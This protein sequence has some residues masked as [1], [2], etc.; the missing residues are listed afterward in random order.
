MPIF[1][2]HLISHIKQ[3]EKKKKKRES[4]WG[5][6]DMDLISLNSY[7]I[8]VVADIAYSLESTG[9]GRV[10]C[11][12]RAKFSVSVNGAYHHHGLLLV[13]TGKLVCCKTI[14]MSLYA[15]HA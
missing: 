7:V 11:S 8:D 2:R 15:F 12:P 14:Y 1:F 5:I 9:S 4:R 13:F 3:G 6:E 10:W